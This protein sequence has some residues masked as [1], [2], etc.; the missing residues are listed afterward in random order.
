MVTINVYDSGGQQNVPGNETQAT[1]GAAFAPAPTSYEAIND[2][3]GGE[4]PAPVLEDIESVEALL[5]FSPTPERAP[6][7]FASDSDAPM[8]TRMPDELF[9]DNGG[10]EAGDGPSETKS[11]SRK[12]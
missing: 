7:S 6:E 1:L 8:P 3:G 2:V 9:G 10:G 11:S 12:K 4:I 5:E